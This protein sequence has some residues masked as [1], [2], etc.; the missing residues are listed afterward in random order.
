VLTSPDSFIA[1]V[2]RLLRGLN[3]DLLLPIT[4]ASLLALL[5]E[6][7]RLRVCIPFADDG[8]VRAIS[9]KAHLL[10]AAPP[11]G[12]AI[13][14]QRV[15]RHAGEWDALL[16]G[17]FAFPVVLKP[18]R[19]VAEL[20]GRR[21]KLEVRHAATR[22]QLENELRVLDPAAYPVLVQQRIVGPGVGIFLLLWN[23]EL[24]ATF[25]HKRIREKPPAGA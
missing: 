14:E 25:A 16:R 12:I 20:N 18:A 5:P 13:P 3:I 7:E 22:A 15:V 9:D 2:E 23:G 11:L 17:G 19:S 8:A 10:Q 24:L 1:G 6:R 21:I 4:E